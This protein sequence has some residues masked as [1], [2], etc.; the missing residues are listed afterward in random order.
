MRR[1]LTP[2]NGSASA[3]SP[4]LEKKKREIK[5]R[6]LIEAFPRRLEKFLSPVKEREA[7]FRP[8]SLG[9]YRWNGRI[10]C[11]NRTDG[12]SRKWTTTTTATK[13]M[14]F[15]L[16]AKPRIPTVV[17]RASSQHCINDASH[18][19]A[20]QNSSLPPFSFF[21][22]RETRVLLFVYF[23]CLFIYS[24]MTESFEAFVVLCSRNGQKERKN[25][26]EGFLPHPFLI[27]SRNRSLFR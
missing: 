15:R 11:G 22:R 8:L 3:F 1:F 23:V 5:R 20:T 6:S 27:F 19:I 18:R 14:G 12:S 26:S 21:L 9:S 25:W 16:P 7:R 17:Y 13:K 10:G 4:V 24:L 2:R